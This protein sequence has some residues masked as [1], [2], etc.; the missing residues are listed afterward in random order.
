[1]AT[2]PR[3][4]GRATPLTGRR[5]ETVV[6]DQLLAAIRSGESRALLVH[7]E[8]GVGRTALLEWVFGV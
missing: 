5:R 8:P 4:Q 6:L 3:S 7:G 1:M 2:H